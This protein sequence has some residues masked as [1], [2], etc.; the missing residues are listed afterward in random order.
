MTNYT[1]STNFATKDT[2][3]SGDPLKIVK[4]TE[5]NT[6]FDNIATAVNSKADTVSPTFTGT[7]TATTLSVIGT[8]SLTGVTTLTAQPILS[9]LAASKPV[10]TDASK[11]LVS[12]GTLGADQGGTGVANNAASTIS[13]SGNFASTFTV[14]GAY[15]YTFPSASGTLSTLAGSE[16]FTNKTFGAGTASVPS[17]KLTSGANLTSATAGAIEYDGK[18][19]YATPLGAQRGIVPTQQYYRL[20][21]ALVGAN[22]TGAQSMFGVGATLSSSTVYEF[23]IV[24]PLSKTAGTG[25]HTFSIGFGGTATLNNI[26]YELIGNFSTTSFTSISTNPLIFYIQTASATAISGAISS[27]A[28]YFMIVIK[29]TVSINA[30]G[31]FIPQYT[32]SAAPGGAYSTVVGSYIRLNPLSTSG[33]ATNVGTW[34]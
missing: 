7:V 2:L 30:G 24:A 12:T 15:N 26:G 18:I 19:I 32:M 16:T 25:S 31:T 23:E 34:A 13:I 28:T 6:E 9:S 33:A 10:F 22:V 11:G 29:G 20:D 21:S 8:S 14:S 17:I 5:I 3:T 4:G 1:K 27:A